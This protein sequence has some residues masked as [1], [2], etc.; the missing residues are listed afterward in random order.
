MRQVELSSVNKDVKVVDG[1]LFFGEKEA[2]GCEFIKEKTI[3]ALY[4]I[5]VKEANLPYDPR[6]SFVCGL[7]LVDGRIWLGG[8]QIDMW[9]DQRQMSMPSAYYDS[10]SSVERVLNNLYSDTAGKEWAVFEEEDFE[11]YQEAWDDLPDY[12]D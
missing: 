6:W 4:V 3:A 5:R 11:A 10:W 2:I 7:D 8:S 1:K 12:E 9:K